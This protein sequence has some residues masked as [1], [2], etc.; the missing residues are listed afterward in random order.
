MKKI[1]ILG[2]TGSIGTQTL[3]VADFLGNV[4][5]ESLSAGGNIKL[6]E[7]QIRK[8]KPKFAAVADEKKA[9]ELKISVA[10][11]E[12]KILSGEEKIALVGL[13]YVGMPIAVAFA[14]KVKEYVKADKICGDKRQNKKCSVAEY[15][16]YIKQTLILF[17]HAASSSRSV[18]PTT[19]DKSAILMI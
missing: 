10:D 3:E 9:S 5:I 14:K 7:E 13:G 18:K 8:Y 16:Q 12:T 15:I 6:L 11:T 2:S 19:D 17:Y 1:S 4:Q